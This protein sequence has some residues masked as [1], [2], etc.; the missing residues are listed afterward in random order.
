MKT[1]L[2][3]FKHGAKSLGMGLFVFLLLP[4]QTF[5]QN[6]QADAARSVNAIL[7]FATQSDRED[8][9]RTLERERFSLPDRASPVAHT[10]LGA[11]TQTAGS[12]DTINRGQRA[13]VIHE[14]MSEVIKPS[15]VAA[16][17]IHEDKGFKD[18]NERA[19]K[20]TKEMAKTI[21]GKLSSHN[22]FKLAA[23]EEKRD[24]KEREREQ[25]FED[26]TSSNRSDLV[27]QITDF[28]NGKEGRSKELERLAFN[29]SD[30]GRSG[31]GGGGGNASVSKK[32][33]GGKKDDTPASP[34]S[35]DAGKSDDKKSDD[36]KS[37]DKKEDKGNGKDKK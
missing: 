2:H 25:K 22:D 5:A 12:P 17:V 28:N 10:V 8:R 23:I 4:F 21:E 13:A 6:R 35:N 29:K 20:I 33:E 19:E 24:F 37:D 30:N 15:E 31:K 34:K 1:G 26:R 3:R 32:D 27:S 9:N 36:K 18:D 11:I 16:N 14:A 7:N